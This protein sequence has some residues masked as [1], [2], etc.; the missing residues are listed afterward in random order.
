MA[1]SVSTNGT[2]AFHGACLL[3]AAV[4][5]SLCPYQSRAQMAYSRL[6]SCILRT[7]GVR[8]APLQRAGD[9]E[10][11]QKLLD[12]AEAA[13]ANAASAAMEAERAA[14]DTSL[15]KQE[16]EQRRRYSSP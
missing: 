9:P 3:C 7:L 6:T 14:A 2:D 11:V 1:S 8:P 16:A 12:E 4:E 15:A 5:P 10:A 13:I